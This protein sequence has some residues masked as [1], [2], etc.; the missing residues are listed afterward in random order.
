MESESYDYLYVVEWSTSLADQPDYL[1]FHSLNLQDGVDPGDFLD[2]I[3][4]QGFDAAAVDT[5]GGSVSAQYI[6]TDTTGRPP[7]GFERVH[8]DTQSLGTILSTTK[9]QILR[10]WR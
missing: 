7:T 5:R 8:L 6:L 9:F 3:S 1:V 2:A 10:S 4:G